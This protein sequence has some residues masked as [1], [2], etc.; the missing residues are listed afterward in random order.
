MLAALLYFSLLARMALA[1]SS[2]CAAC[3]FQSVEFAEAAGE[4]TVGGELAYFSLLARMV[5]ASLSHWAA[6]A[7][8]SMAVGASAPMEEPVAFGTLGTAGNLASASLS[9]EAPSAAASDPAKW[10]VCR[11]CLSVPEDACQSCAVSAFG[12]EA[13][14]DGRISAARGI[15]ADARASAIRT[16]LGMGRMGPSSMK[17]GLNVRGMESSAR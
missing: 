15:A 10:I 2:H 5:L 11:G 4:E 1:S 6:C 17:L 7:F 9:G 12:A 14:A 3:A 8:Q 13:P 16:G